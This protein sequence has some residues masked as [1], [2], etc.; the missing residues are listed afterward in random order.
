MDID[1]DILSP[2]YIKNISWAWQ[3]IYRSVVIFERIIVLADDTW[4]NDISD[5]VPGE[6]CVILTFAKTGPLVNQQMGISDWYGVPPDI[7]EFDD[8]DPIVLLLKLLAIKFF[9]IWKCHVAMSQAYLPLL[10]EICLLKTAVSLTLELLLLE[11]EQKA[12]TLCIVLK[13]GPST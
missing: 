8:C 7:F 2:E 12:L 11:V 13:F 4:H 10:I 1:G 9:L 5:Y 6:V 3:R